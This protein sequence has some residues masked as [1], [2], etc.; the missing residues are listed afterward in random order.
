[1]APRP[2]RRAPLTGG[3]HHHLRRAAEGHLHGSRPARPLPGF[4]GHQSQRT[5]GAAPSS[6]WA[7]STPHWWHSPGLGRWSRPGGTF[8]P[9]AALALERMFSKESLRG[10]ARTGLGGQGRLRPRRSARWVGRGGRQPPA[11][12]GPVQPVPR[13]ARVADISGHPQPRAGHTHDRA[14]RPGQVPSGRA[15]IAAAGRACL[16]LPSQP[17]RRGDHAPARGRPAR[18][19]CCCAVTSTG[20]RHRRSPRQARRCSA[21]TALRFLGTCGHWAAPAVG[22]GESGSRVGR[23]RCGLS[24]LPPRR[25]RHHDHVMGTQAV[26]GGG[27]HHAAL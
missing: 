9:G 8:G 3:L 24:A 13:C 4:A 21:P 11:H 6:P 7:T 1:M 15:G 18:S 14:A 26:R 2:A 12:V 16:L 5:A 10:G 22:G 25:P 17:R 27:W 20:H 19:S 23:G